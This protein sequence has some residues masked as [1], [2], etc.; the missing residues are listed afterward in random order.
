M[1]ESATMLSGT[2]DL[3]LVAISVAV[4]ILSSFVAL[5][6][7]PRI[8]S[9]ENMLWATLRCLV[10]GMSLGAGIW[11][12]HFTAM[13]AF[14]LP[15]QVYYDVTLT[16]LSLFLAIAICSIAILP[17]RSR[18]VI[19]AG[20]IVSI[21][22]IVGFGIAGM[23]YTGMA[24]MR[25]GASMSYSPAIVVLSIVIAIIAASASLFI[26]NYLRDTVIF[27]Q[28]KMKI[29][30]AIVMGLAI[31]SMHYTAMAGVTFLSQS[32]TQDYSVLINPYFLT[33]VV[34]AISLLIQ[35]G[36][37]IAA[38][39]DEAY[40]AARKAEK[41][42]D[43]Q[44][45]IDQTLF[46]IL[47]VTLEKYTLNE[48]L[49]YTLNVLLDNRWLSF[50]NKGSIYLADSNNETLQMIAH[51][52]LDSSVVN[53]CNKLDFGTCLCGQAAQSRT[54]IH[55]SCIDHDHTIQ[56]EGMEPHGH[57]C[58]PVMKKQGVL[59]VI[60]LYIKSGHESSPLE[61]RFLE[62]VSNALAGIIE[63][64]RLEE[65]LEKISNEDELTG[66]PNRRQFNNAMKHALNIGKRTQ[67]RFAVMMMDLDY[68]KQVNDSYG[69]DV[70]DILLQQVA[71]R[72]LPC[73]RDVDMLARVGGDEFIILLEMIDPS[74]KIQEV[75]NRLLSELKR[76]FEINGHHVKIGVSIGVSI[77]PDNGSS[78]DEIFKHA[79]LSLYKAKETRGAMQL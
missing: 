70:G 66:L 75:G 30:A 41:I 76:P 65:K 7:V 19:S 61:L 5:A 17:L 11:T 74:S 36:T 67:H 56:P 49:D 15:V 12:M 24:A 54:I 10:F 43:Q 62:S 59:G 22:T 72:A 14:Q 53:T 18:G 37:F 39:L 4:A 40:F 27:S 16:I 31:S 45:E 46:S 25:M 33:G 68:F 35:G 1:E 26:A 60:N 73:L 21:G 78:Y 13:L 34:V 2:Y 38:L 79:D 20:K 23:H 69:H 8:Y 42:S 32:S 52:N 28:I 47:A 71:Q 77:Y 63:R 55:K 64:K 9:S 6:T 57:Y 51:K 3:L 50:E 48:T 44:S 29:A 58:I